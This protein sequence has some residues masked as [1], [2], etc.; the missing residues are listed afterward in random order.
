MRLVGVG[1]AEALNQVFK[2][3][4]HLFIGFFV[5][6]RWQIESHPLK[7]RLN[8]QLTLPAFEPKT[9]RVAACPIGMLSEHAERWNLFGLSHAVGSHLPLNANEGV[10]FGAARRK[11]SHPAF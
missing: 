7:L 8:T 1:S 5:K 2:L 11:L 3:E 10:G 9:C 6:R 4:G